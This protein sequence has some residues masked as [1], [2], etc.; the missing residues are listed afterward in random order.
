MAILHAEDG[1][2]VVIDAIGE[3]A[4]VSV[5]NWAE[6]LSKLAE[7]GKDPEIAAAE[8]R[9]AEGSRRALSIEPLTAADCVAAARLR[10][11]TRRQGLSLADRACLALA[12]RLNVPALTADR[13]WLTADVAAEVRLIR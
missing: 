2:S 10:P 13:E 5:V 7:A 12:Q 1:A 3:G 6:V 8:L 11:I 9:R 4:A